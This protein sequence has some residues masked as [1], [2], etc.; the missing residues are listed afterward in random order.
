MKRFAALAVFAFALLFACSALRAQHAGA[1]GGFSGGGA[2]HGSSGFHGSFSAPASRGL[3]STSHGSTGFA[4]R[5]ASRQFIAPRGAQAF[6]RMQRPGVGAYRGR[7]PYSGASADSRRHRR[8]YISPFRAGYG[9]GGPGWIAPYYLSS[10]DF[11]Y[12]DSGNDQAA[13]SQGYDQQGP[14]QQDQQYDQQ[15][16]NQ[17]PLNPYP[18]APYPPAYSAPQTAQQPQEAV[19]LIFKDGRPPE[20][21]HNYILT[22]NTLF[23]GDSR[24]R[25]IPVDQLDLIA[26]VRVNQ[27]AGVDFRLPA[28][29]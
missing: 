4:P 16:D 7:A 14:D 22:A 1:H 13:A 28:S 29:R 11:G 23:V 26:T 12:D 2:S 25:Q 27:E 9:Y 15:A 5:P 24:R 17:P 3:S 18:L 6:N 8:P 21:I 10:P 20:Q 19:T